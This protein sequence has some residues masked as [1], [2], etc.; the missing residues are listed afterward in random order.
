[1]PVQGVESLHLAMAARAICEFRD[2]PR[3]AA[4][5]GA[6]MGRDREAKQMQSL[7]RLMEELA[8]DDRFN[9]IHERYMQP[10]ACCRKPELP[11]VV[12]SESVARRSVII[13]P[14]SE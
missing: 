12:E 3:L 6:A 1:M 9:S 14:N 7:Q 13:Y 8:I 5:F 11:S 4:L 10:I 2:D